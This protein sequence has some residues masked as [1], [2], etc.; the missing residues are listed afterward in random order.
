MDKFDKQI[1]GLI[2]RAIGAAIEVHKVLGHGLPEAAYGNALALELESLGISFVKEYSFDIKYKGS[3][4]G[5]ARMD[6]LV[7]NRLVLELKA[8]EQ[9]IDVHK[10]QTRTY[11]WQVK[12][13]VGIL[14]N[15]NVDFLKNGGIHR[16]IDSRLA[17]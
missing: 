6:F 15:F 12:E 5:N 16:I 1:E 11:L 4:I 9:I 10:A 17:S 7:E 13:P 14:F 2:S 8:I 3:Y